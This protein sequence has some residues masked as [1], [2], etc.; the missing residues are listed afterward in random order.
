[1]RHAARP[2]QRRPTHRDDSLQTHTEVLL[3]VE[4]QFLQSDPRLPDELVV[5]EFVLVAHRKPDKG[6]SGGRGTGVP[7]ETL[8]RGTGPQGE[9]E[10]GWFS[11]ESLAGHLVVGDAVVDQGLV[12]R[13]VQGGFQGLGAKLVGLRDKMNR[14]T[15]LK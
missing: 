11:P 5:S 1:M 4:L 15:V 8:S 10:A 2:P 14:V 12:P 13:R 3:L 9:G 7:G 6:T